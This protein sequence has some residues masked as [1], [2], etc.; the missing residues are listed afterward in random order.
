MSEKHRRY[1]NERAAGW[2]QL[3]DDETLQRLDGIINGLNIQPGSKILDVGTGTG[4]LI[5]F[6]QKALEGSGSIVA[7][8]LA[9][10]MLKRAKE[11][12]GE[13]Q[14]RYVMGDIAAAPFTENFFDEV[15]CNSCFPH[16]QN[17]R[18]AV[19]EMFRILKPGCRAVV[20]H[21]MSR[22]QLDSMHK[23]LDSVVYADRLPDND[24]MRSLFQEAGFDDL[25]ISDWSAGYLLTAR[26]NKR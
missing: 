1:F 4:V 2:D 13:R 24:T 17:K 8:D 15:I 22:E 26:K 23:A 21:T 12:H 18:G 6:L 16:F 7:L 3:L 20:C 9:E 19:Q 10:E 25:A 11:K 14:I 5:P